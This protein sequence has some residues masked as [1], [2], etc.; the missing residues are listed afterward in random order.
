MK[1]NAMRL[2]DRQ[3]IEYETI[4]YSISNDD[5][6]AVQ[7]AIQLGIPFNLLFKTLVCIDLN[8][9]II[10]A[11]IPSNERLSTKKLEKVSG[12]KEPALLPVD[13]LPSRT[14]Y[15]RGGCSP[16]AMKKRYP[17]FIDSSISTEEHIWIN[18]GKKGCLLQL[19]VKDL[20]LLT[21]GKR[22]DIIR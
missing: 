7:I 9:Q 10:I 12:N 5:F 1:T 3:K 2:L 4:A 6:D 16:L 11:V 15:I 18:A 20:L 17:T 14:G 19:K 8:R 13:A 22:E 21:E